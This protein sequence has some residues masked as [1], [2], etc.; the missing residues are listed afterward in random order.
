MR[1]WLEAGTGEPTLV[2][3]HG[4]GGGAESWRG[5]LDAFGSRARC[6]A[7]NAPGYGGAP[8]IEPFTWEGLTD[9]LRTALDAAGVERAMLIG[10]SMGGMVAQSLIA[11][12]PD[13]VHSLVLSAT[14]P[15]FGRA[16][17]DWQR[18]FVSQR[19]APLDEGIGMAGMAQR[20]LPA[21]I[22][23]HTA[24]PV[25]REIA[26]IMGDVPETT[27]RAAMTNLVTFD[28]RE[29]LA[30]IS[31]PTVVVAGGHDTMAPA[32][33]MQRMSERIA[34]ARFACI[35]NAGHL[36]PMEHPEAFDVHI[37]DL[38]DVTESA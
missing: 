1:V 33:M 30:G 24:E 31:V 5:Q 9:R 6:L 29:N 21:L 13:R 38:L 27:Y 16:D 35:E 20:L 15:A 19:L 4:V 34:G 28:A 14:S 12:H 8:M 23:P 3:L 26:A 22:G 17:G 11:A 2:F 25:R 7:W 32:A 37:E 18:E 10:H 36:A